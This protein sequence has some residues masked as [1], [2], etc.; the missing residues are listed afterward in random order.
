M[1]QNIIYRIRLYHLTLFNFPCILINSPWDLP[2]HLSV[3]AVIIIEPTEPQ[4][5][6][7]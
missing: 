6:Q 3:T 1:V 4:R 5:K 7:Q 2:V